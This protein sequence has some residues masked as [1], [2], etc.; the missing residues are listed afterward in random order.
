M[1]NKCLISTSIF[2]FTFTRTWRTCVSRDCTSM[3]SYVQWVTLPVPT[4][5]W[6]ER[7]EETGVMGQTSHWTTMGVTEAEEGACPAGE[8]CQEGGVVNG[9]DRLQVKQC[10]LIY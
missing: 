10:T 3:S 9:E 1:E 2:T 7:E 8:G 5:P 6:A 4:P